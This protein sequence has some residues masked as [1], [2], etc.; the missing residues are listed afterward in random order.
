MRR[1]TE[2]GDSVSQVVTGLMHP[3]TKNSSWL[4]RRKAM[5]CALLLML[6][7]PASLLQRL[8]AEEGIWLFNSIPDSLRSEIKR[9]YR[10][11]LQQP[12]LDHLR[13]AS[14]HFNGGSGSFVSPDGL[15]FT[16]HHVASGC[17]QSLSSQENDYMKN[18]F[19]ARTREEEKQ[20]PGL[21]VRVLSEI[22]DVT[23]QVQSAA[24]D[25]ADSAEG[26]RLRKAEMSKIENECSADGFDCNVITLYAGGRYHLYRYKEYDD[27]RLVFAPESQIAFFGGDP[28]NFSYPRYC[29][30]ITF[31]RAYVDGK[32]AKPENYLRWSKRGMRDGELQFVSGHPGSTGRLNTMAQLEFFR[33][34]SYPMLLKRVES[35]IA[36]AMAYSDR[37]DEEKRIAL[38]VIF[39]MQNT[40]K[41]Y[42]GFLSG[43]RDNDLMDIKR[44]QEAELRAAISK[45]DDL[46]QQYG[47]V[48]DTLS[49]AMKS[50][51]EIYERSLLFE[52]FAVRG[53]TLFSFA[54]GINRYAEEIEKPN[55]D[56]LRGFNDANIP[57]LKR[58]FSRDV[59]V[60]PEFETIMLANGLTALAERFP[61]DETV[62]KLLGGKTP[63]DVAQAAVSAS[64]LAD[65]ELRAAMMDDPKKIRES[66]DSLL[67]LVRILEPE[68]RRL[69]VKYQD[70]IEPTIVASETKIAQARFALYGEN[71]YP[72]ATLTLRLSL[73]PVRG[74]TD[75][76]G[77]RIPAF[78][79]MGDVFKKATG[80][81]PYILPD[82]WLK[83]RAKLR[84]RTPFNYITT[85]DIH[86]GNS[87][88]PAVN[89]R[90]EVVGIVFDGNI[91][92]LPN[93]FIYQDRTA[94]AVFVASQAVVESLD[95]IYDAEELLRELGIR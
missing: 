83:N 50:Y 30:D 65:K 92:S 70:A 46:K 86:G 95:K 20:C 19:H 47:T 12:F 32:P 31:L 4:S 15:L 11:D 17:V 62:K 14:V 73:G 29:L 53:S 33:D 90:G 5:T 52:T 80:E 25:E 24:G 75:T 9:Q 1:Y 85:A 44:K 84:A 74:F 51:A 57:N 3:F 26:N 40:K 39:G 69:I 88:S 10:F 94:R 63:M 41:A 89:T 8:H 81:D 13:T 7:L 72:D 61:D 67:A 36:D 43:L 38:D 49:A 42:T 87:G 91:P 93:R 58:I 71:D 18:G 64:K 27:V 22:R 6:L 76:D 82:S 28:D 59:P 45:D 78:T 77:T 56:R 79:T 55:D 60:Y 23:S 35:V 34:V 37:G 2:D 21:R 54:R 16:N 66:D 68:S 48:W